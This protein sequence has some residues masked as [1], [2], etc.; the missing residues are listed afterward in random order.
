MFTLVTVGLLLLV[1]VGILG[2]AAHQADRTA[3]RV[4]LAT[5]RRVRNELAE[6]RGLKSAPEMI[7]EEGELLEQ[8]DGAM[9]VLGSR[10]EVLAQ[11]RRRVPS[12]PRR[13]DDGWRVLAVRSRDAT[14]V[15]GIPWSKTRAALRSQ[16]ALLF[17]LVMFVALVTALGAWVLVGHTLSPIRALSR[18]ANSAT[19]EGLRVRLQAPSSD[20]ELVELVGTLN[21]LLERLTQAAAARGRFYAAA[22]HE[23]R[24]PLQALSGHLELALTR[25]RSAAEYRTVV[26]EAYA[27]TRRLTHLVRE[28]LLLNQLHQGTTM[29]PAEPVEVCGIAWRALHQLRATLE[30]RGLAVESELPEEVEILAP[31]AHVDILVRNLAENAAKYAIPETTVRLRVAPLSD[32]ALFEI[33][34]DCDASL[35]VRPEQVFEPFFRPDASR[36]SGTGGN[37]LG[38]AICKA[39]ADTHGWTLAWA[40]EEDVVRASVVFRASRRGEEV[41]GLPLK[42]SLACPDV[43]PAVSHS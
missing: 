8:A 4:L 30:E 16:A 3:D 11:S 1:S 42:E 31:P 23:L 35:V 32:G 25:P 20:A 15:L 39:V 14:I 13:E 28:L 5:A 37:G 7:R 24:T 9:L 27:Q 38:L 12:W 36:S 19:P 41:A 33:T 40:R 2:Y 10:G 21:G 18:Q 6:A 34:N 43:I 22:S 17:G 26:D 29:P